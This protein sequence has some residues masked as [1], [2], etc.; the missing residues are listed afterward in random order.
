MNKNI[1]ILILFITLFLYGRNED[2]NLDKLNNESDKTP[3]NITPT[4]PLK[5]ILTSKE[6]NIFDVLIY[7]L[8]TEKERIL[9][10]IENIEK[11]RR[12]DKDYYEM[13]QESKNKVNKYTK[14][15]TWILDNTRKQEQ[16]E[17]SNAFSYT[18]N[19]I[20]NKRKKLAS[21]KHQNTKE[22]IQGAYYQYQN[23]EYKKEHTYNEDLYGNSCTRGASCIEM[24][25][26]YILHISMIP[27]EYYDTNEEIF[28]KMKHVLQNKHDY[29]YL[30]ELWK[31]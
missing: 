26:F 25:F 4:N 1:N 29:Q 24:L 14:F 31:Y 3:I 9:L 16:K 6:K 20:E 10:E 27:K 15:R 13:N 11:H 12:D 8:D 7:A 23:D 28:K 19:F 21:N 5:S 22:Y 2:K 30:F 17:L 18:Y